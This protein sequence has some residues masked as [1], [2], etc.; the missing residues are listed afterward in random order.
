MKGGQRVLTLLLA[1]TSSKGKG[2]SWQG[3]EQVV[4]EEP[5][6]CGGAALGWLCPQHLGLLHPATAPFWP[7]KPVLKGSSGKAPPLALRAVEPGGHGDH[8]LPHPSFPP[9]AATG[10][11]SFCVPRIILTECAP[12][13]P[14]PPESRLEEPGPR[15]APTPRP[16]TLP[17]RR[18]GWDC[19]RTLPGVVATASQPR[20]SLMPE[21]E[22]AA[23]QRL[24]ATGCS[25]EKGGAGVP[26]ALGLAPARTQE[27]PTAETPPEE[28]LKDSGHDAQPC[29]GE[30]PGQCNAGLGHTGH[31]AT[32]QRMDSLEETLRELE[33]TLNQLGTDPATGPAGSPPP[34]A[35]GPQVAAS[36]PIFSSCL[37]APVSSE[38]EGVGG[39]RSTTPT[40][41]SPWPSLSTR[42]HPRS[43][44]SG[45]GCRQSP[46]EAG[47][48]AYPG[49]G[50]TSPGGDRASPLCSV[51]VNQQIK[52]SP[53]FPSPTLPSP[54]LSALCLCCFSA[55]ASGC[56]EPS[57]Q[58]WSP[59]GD[60][61]GWTIHL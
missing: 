44:A 32:T 45:L 1:W 19:P 35:P 18:R 28:M 47:K 21:Q 49:L 43:L 6:Q 8:A 61:G 37:Q 13:P 16:R 53:P 58:A 34:P 52:F 17:G 23:L 11:R 9:Q 10:P 56:P 60:S 12:N 4:D 30:H 14:S 15:T 29:R 57:G 22:G 40:S 38:L 54:L 50:L 59:W 2:P 27:P 48:L 25:P 31:G 7:W 41:S 5:G 46:R 39:C 42:H 36:S 24:E 3:T 20:N 51:S 55:C 33:A 26:C